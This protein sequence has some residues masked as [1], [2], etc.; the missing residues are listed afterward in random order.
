M[1]ELEKLVNEYKVQELYTTVPLGVYCNNPRAYPLYIVSDEDI[2]D[3][4]LE[5]F[6][7]SEVI[8][9][10]LA[11][12]NDTRV[13]SIVEIITTERPNDILKSIFPFKIYDSEG[14]C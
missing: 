2:S 6:Y 10:I 8:R 11:S 3:K 14:W 5:A 12:G 1:T 9:R 7:G 4:V 13:D